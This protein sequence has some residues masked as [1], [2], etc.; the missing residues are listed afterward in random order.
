MDESFVY[1][2]PSMKLAL[3]MDGSFGYDLPSMIL[4]LFMDGDLTFEDYLI[5]FGGKVGF[6]F[7]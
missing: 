7:G 4:A 1:G 2:F 3:F 5:C 6:V